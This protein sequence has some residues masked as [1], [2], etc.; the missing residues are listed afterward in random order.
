[1]ALTPQLRKELKNPSGTLIQGSSKRTIEQV[2]RLVIEQN[3]PVTISVGDVVTQNLTKQHV[4][5][6]VMIMD[7]KVLRQVV[8]PIKAEAH[9]TLYVKNPPGTITPEAWIT[10]K[11]AIKQSGT[12]KVVVD[13]EEDLLALVAALEAPTDSL[14]IYGQPH[15]GL[16]VI[17]VSPQTKKKMQKILDRMR[18]AVEKPK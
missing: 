16:V 18:P 3:P 2:R 12:T 7:N 9:T 15:E 8:Q 6:Q 10:I 14:V 1:M 5:V 4:P 17:R 13:G 11:Q